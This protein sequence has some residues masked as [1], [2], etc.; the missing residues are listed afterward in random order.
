MVS[1]EL[2]TALV[3]GDAKKERPKPSII[4]E[5]KIKLSDEFKFI[6]NIITKLIKVIPIP[7]DDII[8]GS[9]LSD[10]LPETGEKIAIIT[11]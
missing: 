11:G 2:I 6:K 3:F 8:L 7:I 10:I 1:T 9:I 5:D 4:K